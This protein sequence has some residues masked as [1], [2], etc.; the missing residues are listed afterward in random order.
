MSSDFKFMV[1]S[2][3]MIKLRAEECS[4]NFC[5]RSEIEN[6]ELKHKMQIPESKE[7]NISDLFFEEIPKGNEKLVKQINKFKGEG[8]PQISLLMAEVF[9]I[10]NC[11]KNTDN[12][13]IV[14]IGAYPGDHINFLASF[15]PHF[16]FHLYDY[17]DEKHETKIGKGD[18]SLLKNIFIYNEFFNDKIALERYVDGN[19]NKEIYIISDIR[20]INY[21]KLGNTD[22][23][24]SRILDNDTYSQIR[25][26]Q[27][28]KPKYALLKYRPKLPNEIVTFHQE[29]TDK[30]ESDDS[31]KLYF[32][33]PEGKFLRIPYQKKEQRAVY[34]F[35]NKYELT[36]KYFHHDMISAIK[37]HH[38]YVRR[39]IIYDNPFEE[40]F[41][42]NKAIFGVDDVMRVATEH[43]IKNFNE[44]KSFEYCLGCDWDSRACVF[45]VMVLVKYLKNISLRENSHEG[46]KDDFKK[47]LG[48]YFV[49]PFIYIRHLSSTMEKVEEKPNPAKL[50][51]PVTY[52]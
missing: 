35:T 12:V 52:W 9:F 33:Y 3:A 36:E 21:Q 41:L 34:F 14:Y 43:D 50:D 11:V 13:L 7:F 17:K 31:R 22:V 37:L 20:D 18:F 25:W 1:N 28:I 44:E 29:L 24:N 16:I 49:Y 15:F 6:G 8:N 2:N 42:M 26:C 19:K 40:D 5:F 30:D 39:S 4:L 47:Y 23:A 48:E 10:C 46:I 38:G 51:T 32:K 27:I 45:I